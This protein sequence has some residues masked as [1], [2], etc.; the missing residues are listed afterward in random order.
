MKITFSK[1]TI[2]NFKGV[3]GERTLEFSPTMTQIF[4]ANH[5]GK[6]TI[7]DAALWLLFGKNSAGEAKFG[8]DPKDAEGKVI[9]H[10]ENSVELTMDA[11][12]KTSTLRKSRR[13]VWTKP[14]GR[15]EEELTSHT[16]LYFVDGQKYTENDYKEYIGG[17]I[18][19]GLFRSIT[20]PLYFPNLKA[21]DQRALLTKMVGETGVEHMAEGKEEFEELV[22]RMNGQD[23]QKYME[24]LSYRL[25]ELKKELA[26]MPSRIE[27]N[28]NELESLKA[29]GT[30]FDFTRKRIAEIEKG[31]AQCDE[32]I[33]DASKIAD[34]LYEKKMKERNEINR[35]KIRR[36]EIVQSYKDRNVSVQRKHTEAIQ[37]AEESLES[38]KVSVRGLTYELESAQKELASIERKTEDFRRR[39]NDNASRTFEW[40]PSKETC[41]TCGQRLPE[42]DIERTRR[43]MEANFNTAT[44]DEQAELENEASEIKSRKSA[45]EALTLDASKRLKEIEEEI[46]RKQEYADGIKAEQPVQT[47]HLDDEEYQQL[48]KEIEER[49]AKLDEISEAPNVPSNDRKFELNKKRDELRDILT[50]EQRIRDKE[51]RIEELKTQQK[52]M[53]QQLADIEKEQYC[54]ES[55]SNACTED[56]QKRVNEMF[57]NV[58]F[59]MFEHQMNGGVKPICECTL[60][61]TPYQDLSNSEKINAGLDIINAVCRYNDT[62]APCFIDNAESINDVIPMRSQQILLIVSF[63]KELRAIIPNQK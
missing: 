62:Y 61:G 3:L 31:I 1:I 30:N 23:M 50:D 46:A 59:R 42:G 11:D 25:T 27:E 53:N 24:H 36:N 14:R 48:T 52:E 45:A 15:E 41:P 37:E 55:L 56:L 22:K 12:G 19:E 5:T 16:T 9:H 29:K 35:M 63:D 57:T 4:G 43:E 51:R 17:I 33:R 18:N 38:S 39:W 40:D 6:T 8:I 28:S 54:C 26:T 58:R 34:T 10:L 32:E 21:D 49:T 60:H 44:A 47:S 7:V 2:Q 13:E 20:N